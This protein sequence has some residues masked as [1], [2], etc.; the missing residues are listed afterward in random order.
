MP[1]AGETPA[2]EV[3]LALQSGLDVVSSH[4]GC[5]SAVSS[6]GCQK[7]GTLRAR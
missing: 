3:C 2:P 4:A 6:E 5:I 7:S 1:E